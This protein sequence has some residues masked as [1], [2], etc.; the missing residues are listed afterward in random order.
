[1][2]GFIII[3]MQN[4][5]F[6]GSIFGLKA[7]LVEVEADQGGGEF[8]KINI[9]GLPDATV[10]ESQ[11]RIRS[12]IKN[13]GY[14]FP[15]RKLTVNLAPAEV[16]KSGSH[17]DL[18]IAIA[19]LELKNKFIGEPRKIFIAG[20]LSLSGKTKEISSVLPLVILAAKNGF[21][22]I[23]IPK[24]NCQEASFVKEIK[25]YPV[26]SLQQLATHLYQK[27]NLTEYRNLNKITLHTP[28]QSELWTNIIGQSQAK[29]AAEISLAGGH[30][31]LMVGPPG[32]G[33][34]M[35]AKAMSK[36]SPELTQTQSLEIANIHSI[37]GLKNLDAHKFSHGLFRSVHHSSSE[38]AILG[39]G[40][41][42]R[43]GEI[44]LCHYGLLFFDELTQFSKKIINSLRQPMEENEIL[45]S[46]AGEFCYFPCSFTLIAA[47]NPCPCGFYGDQKNKCLC[48][49][50]QL[51]GY[52]QKIPGPI[53]ERFD[54]IIWVNNNPSRTTTDYQPSNKNI[55]KARIIQNTRGFLNGRCN[56]VFFKK[57]NVL[58]ENEKKFF[59]SASE[60]LKCSERS[61]VRII[62]LARTIADLD[63]QPFIKIE[64]LAEA[65]SLR[66]S[67]TICYN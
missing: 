55:Q 21:K 60:T 20:E 14:Q 37:Y 38:L 3:I 39:G 18:P 9:V 17:Y 22:E 36:N 31:L 15:K 13:S 1:M 29:R 34:T 19:I 5:I 33:K 62:K 51:T 32:S 10:Q 61:K 11:E 58:G 30:H 6:C 64:H 4:K 8:G 57:I 43:P 63:Q 42:L 23:F 65:F 40:K 25:I 12:A 49:P 45:I 46:H 7:T 47:T 35:I 26:D 52:Q 44:S 16:K 2:D 53:L 54:L 27:N 56:E 66:S 28:K 48:R 67:E 24:D 50:S 59:D 41:K